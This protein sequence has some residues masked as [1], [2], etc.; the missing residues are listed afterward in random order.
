MITT[1]NPMPFGKTHSI[2][3]RQRLMPSLLLLPPASCSCD[4]NW[5]QR[6]DIH[7][8]MQGVCGLQMETSADGTL[9]TAAP[10]MSSDM[11]A[12]HHTFSSTFLAHCL[13]ISLP[14][15]AWLS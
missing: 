2:A 13:E 7:L 4:T 1:A 9:Q 8:Q 3:F 15:T 11:L 5:L 6:P 14:C 10:S 12:T